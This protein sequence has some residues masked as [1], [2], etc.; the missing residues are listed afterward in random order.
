M[1]RGGEE[2]VPSHSSKQEN[3]VMEYCYVE[4]E[5]W[6]ERDGLHWRFNATI[7]L[8]LMQ[9]FGQNHSPFGAN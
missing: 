9:H 5:L 4:D 3:L 7:L 1:Y 2:N 6:M 8:F